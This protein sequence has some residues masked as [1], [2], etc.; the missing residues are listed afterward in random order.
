MNFGHVQMLGIRALRY[1]RPIA[2]ICFSSWLIHD[3]SWG[4]VKTCFTILG[5]WTWWTAIN[6]SCFGV[7][8]QKFD[9]HPTVWGHKLLERLTWPSTYPTICFALQL[10]QAG[11]L[12]KPLPHQE[13]SYGFCSYGI[14]CILMIFGPKV[15]PMKIFPL[16]MSEMSPLKWKATT[17]F[18][19][20]DSCLGAAGIQDS[21]W[22][23][24][25]WGPLVILVGL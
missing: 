25:G 4:C 24:V 1:S 14:L 7:R 10:R 5:G 8:Y 16:S 22:A 12:S 2:I 15:L 23:Y 9:P 21:F 20:H 18:C 6:P 19:W 11:P 13:Q 17:R 3:I